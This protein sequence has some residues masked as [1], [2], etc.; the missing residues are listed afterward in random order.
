VVSTLSSIPTLPEAR[1]NLLGV[2]N[3]PASK[4]LSVLNAPAEQIIGVI[5]AKSEKAA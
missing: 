4:L 1:A 3:A 2:I 5:Q